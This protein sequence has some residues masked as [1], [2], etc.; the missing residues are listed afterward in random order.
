MSIELAFRERGSG[1]PMVLLHAFPLWSAVFD[2]QLDGLAGQA[3]II[4]PDLRG[5]GA[6]PGPGSDEPSLD[7]MADDVV[8]LLDRLDVD[9]CCLGGMSMGGYVAMAVRRRH[10]DRVGSLVLI[11]TKAAAD[12][13]AAREN[14]ERIAR[15][16]LDN[17]ARAL[18]PMIDTLL[19]ET[20]R[21]SRPDV[22]A[23]V[24]GWLDAA[25]PEAV[26]WAQRAMAAR[27]AS[28]D[29]LG[30]A[31]LPAF[32]LVG[33]EDAVTPHD[34]AMAVADAFPRP[35]PVYVIPGAG[36]LS[37]VENP[38]SVTD[39]LRDVLARL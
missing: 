14:R 19:G 9:R 20:T 22:V 4:A 2:A 31:D 21:A 12:D 3:R 23:T 36:H 39:A 32:V 18:R 13:P 28:F 29:V 24:T 33:E 34:Q 11:D 25:R 10:P 38:D 37:S 8:A 15:A 30:S 27:P 5:F 1:T 35:T 7:L 17:G 26:A 16:V 6:S